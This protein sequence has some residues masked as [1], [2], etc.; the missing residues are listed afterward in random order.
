VGAADTTA[1]TTNAT[2]YA[3][4][5]TGVTTPLAV[6][7]TIGATGNAI[8]TVSAETSNSGTSQVRSCW[9]SFTISGA[10]T[11]SSSDST[12]LTAMGADGT[13]PITQH[14]AASFLVSGLNAGSNTF[15][16]QYQ[17]NGNNC[18]FADRNIVVQP[19]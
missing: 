2:S 8:V 13:T 1:G 4:A 14:L 17:A 12:S 10:T 7:A 19:F 11:R 3:T 6:T 5:L 9:M 15:T 18:T 16:P